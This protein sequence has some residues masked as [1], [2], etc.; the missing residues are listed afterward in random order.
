MHSRI[1]NGRSSIFGAMVWMFALS[2]LITLLLWWIPV[3]GPF[4]GPVVGG[5]VGGRRAGSVG[6]ALVAAVLPA[7]LL[8]LL[9]MLLGGAA[10]AWSG[11][12]FI[13]SLATLVAGASSLIAL[14]HNGVLFV[15]ALVGGLA[16]DE[17][18]H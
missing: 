18:I 13:G 15:A 17:G 6:R 11:L 8:F 14:A 7:L 12:P 4:I 3:V 1:L 2:F 16:R 9:I 5:Y 10:T